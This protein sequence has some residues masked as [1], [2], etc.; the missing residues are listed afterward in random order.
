MWNVGIRAIRGPS[1]KGFEMAFKVPKLNFF[2]E[3]SFNG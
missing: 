3:A 1:G 2:R